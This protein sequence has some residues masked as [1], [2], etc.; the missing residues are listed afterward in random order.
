MLVALNSYGKRNF[1]GFGSYGVIKCA[2][3]GGLKGPVI[4]F[5]GRL[6]KFMSRIS[7]GGSGGL[8]LVV[9]VFDSGFSFPNTSKSIICFK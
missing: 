8:G 1:C 4:A 9:G 3:C 7:F 6:L 5:G 2:V